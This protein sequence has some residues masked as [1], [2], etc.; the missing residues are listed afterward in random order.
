ME[1]CE[2]Q[3]WNDSSQKFGIVFL[4][5]QVHITYNLALPSPWGTNISDFTTLYIAFCNLQ[6]LSSDSL[7]TDSF[8]VFFVF[9]D[10][11]GTQKMNKGE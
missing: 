9:Y 2:Q 5:A 8:L 1:Y 3:I 6:R 7:W 11:E 4:K 10:E